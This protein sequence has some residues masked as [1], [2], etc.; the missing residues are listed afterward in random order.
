MIRTNQSVS[1]RR[2][3]DLS[4]DSPPLKS[5]FRQITLE[6]SPVSTG[7]TTQE[8]RAGP[9][10]PVGGSCLQ[11]GNFQQRP[12]KLSA[13]NSSPRS[14]WGITPRW[15][16]VSGSCS[17][18]QLISTGCSY[19]DPH[20]L[21][22]PFPSKTFPRE[23]Y[24]LRAHSKKITNPFNSFIRISPRYLFPP[25]PLDGPMAGPQN[26]KV[27]QQVIDFIISGHALGYS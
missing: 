21:C 20:F 12:C 16:S 23:F 4:G 6:L 11:K 25:H 24:I 15:Q 13:L 19:S 14:R 5:S 7:T 2:S 3:R 22:N 10:C 9:A 27:D 17:C 1:S 26:L 8:L 18:L